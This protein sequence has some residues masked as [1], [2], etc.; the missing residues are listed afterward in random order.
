V[1]RI[2]LA[3]VLVAGLV[4]TPA[5]PAPDA[6][7]FVVAIF[8]PH[9]KGLRRL[10]STGESRWVGDVVGTYPAWSRRA[11][12]IAFARSGSGVWVVRSD[13]SGKRRLTREDYCCAPPSWA[14]DG[15][16]LAYQCHR[17]RTLPP[18]SLFNAVCAVDIRTG[19]Q[20]VIL[21]PPGPALDI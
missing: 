3:F 14:S 1:A 19:R 4:A 10:F 8:R 9:V 17:G 5:A 15:R 13:G 16:S 6:D 11:R 20:R 2:A 12:L 21:R 18:F 7:S